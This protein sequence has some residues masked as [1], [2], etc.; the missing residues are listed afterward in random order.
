[1]LGA[2]FCVFAAKSLAVMVKSRCPAATG[3]LSTR[4]RPSVGPLLPCVW[5]SSCPDSAY[6][7]RSRSGITIPAA[8]LAISDGKAG[9]DSGDV[10][11]DAFSG[12]VGQAL[13]AAPS[14]IFPRTV[15]KGNKVDHETDR[16]PGRWFRRD[17]NRSR[18]SVPTP[19]SPFSY[20]TF[21]FVTISV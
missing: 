11:D 12:L 20:K 9:A 2:T 19:E 16:F 15:G 3:L 1:M 6:R 10:R 8:A 17:G 5:L 13:R 14:R 4:D 7:R 21:P 18:L